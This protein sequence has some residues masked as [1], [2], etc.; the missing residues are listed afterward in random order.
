MWQHDSGKVGVWLMDGTTVLPAAGV[1][2][3]PGPDWHIIA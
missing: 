1:G 3:N 2:T